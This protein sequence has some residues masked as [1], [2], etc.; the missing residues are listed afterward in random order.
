MMAAVI[1]CLETP[2]ER[3]Q[4]LLVCTH[5]LGYQELVSVSTFHQGEYSSWIP[6][7]LMAHCV[8]DGDGKFGKKTSTAKEL[9]SSVIKATAIV[10][11]LSAIF[12]FSSK[13]GA[14]VSVK[15]IEPPKR[16][17]SQCS[18]GNSHKMISMLWAPREV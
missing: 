4:K 6:I 12:P 7:W 1:P 13:P 9:I 5:F 8:R 11:Y 15:F 14:G 2:G 16:R 17:D 18:G 10:S 3:T